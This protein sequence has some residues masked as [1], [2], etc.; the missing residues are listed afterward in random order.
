MSNTN[1]NSF[2][3]KWVDIINFKGISHRRV[4]F[5][6][7]S[8]YLISGNAGE[9]SSVLDALSSVLG[10]TMN[11]VE[12]PV[13]L[14]E[15]QG[16]V[17]ICLTHGEDVYEIHSRFSHKKRTGDLSLNINGERV[18]T[19]VRTKLNQL[20]EFNSFDIFHFLSLDPVDQKKEIKNLTGC[21]DKI[22]KE[23]AKLSVAKKKLSFENQTLE[24]MVS[25]NK[26]EVRPFTDEDVITYENPI[27][28]EPIQ[29]AIEDL[30]PQFD[31]HNQRVQQITEKKNAAEAL[32]TKAN[33]AIEREK[34][35]VEET[36]HHNDSIR[37]YEAEI[38]AIKLKIQLTRDKIGTLNNEYETSMTSRKMLGEQYTAVQAEVTSLEADHASI[39]AP[40]A[41]EWSKKLADATAHNQKHD[42]IQIYRKRQSEIVQKRKEVESLT[43]EI[44]T[45]KQAIRDLFANSDLRVPGLHYN[46][47]GLFLDDLPF[48][49]NQVN[50]AR[51]IDVGVDLSVRMNPKLR[52]VMIRE[53][54]LLDE[55]SMK[56]IT[57]KLHD[58][59]YMFIAEIVDP[60]GA[61]LRVVKFTEEDYKVSQLEG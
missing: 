19:G 43:A 51:F 46:D 60:K 41:E 57:K 29:K 36:N 24:N 53:A 27:P 58:N 15:D 32:I 21:A 39:P 25:A 26:K 52:L 20:L 12:E 42:L 7:E 38:E 44:D 17:T 2:L 5:D 47:E 59:G 9:K 23:E 31:A 56:R 6:G 45:Y 33:N 61:D 22:E 50:T 28:I 3:L 11:K 8:A 30:Q 37:E 13:K 18:K 14:G 16:E 48:K 4:D 54:S 55:P 1:N 34:R 35:I 49:R 40:N 10:S